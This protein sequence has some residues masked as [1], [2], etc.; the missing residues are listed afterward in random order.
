M[1][2][3]TIMSS[4]SVKPVLPERIRRTSLNPDFALHLFVPWM[5]DG[6]RG[7]NTKFAVKKWGRSFSCLLRLLQPLSGFAIRLCR[8]DKNTVFARAE[9]PKQ[10]LSSSEIASSLT[11]V[12]SSQ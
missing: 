1:M 12:S 2:T 5:I 8:N 9:G 7:P 10:S 11:S 4:I 3:I 6:I